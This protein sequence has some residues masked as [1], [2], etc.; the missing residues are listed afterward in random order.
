L[1]LISLAVNAIDESTTLAESSRLAID[2][3][4]GHLVRCPGDLI[5]RRSFCGCSAKLIFPLL[6]QNHNR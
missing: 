6:L 3:E 1:K 5:K 4:W 2:S